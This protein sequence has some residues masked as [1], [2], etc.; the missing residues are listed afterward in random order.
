LHKT[1][2]LYKVAIASSLTPIPKETWGEGIAIALYIKC[3]TLLQGIHLSLI[4]EL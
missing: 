2:S 3:A 1:A 4:K